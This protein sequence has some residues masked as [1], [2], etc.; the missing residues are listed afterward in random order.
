MKMMDFWMR[1]DTL[2]AG[3]E[4]CIDR[5][6]GSCHPGFPN[7]VY[8]LDYGYL[9][10]TAGG[11]GNEIDVWCGSIENCG[12]VAVICTVDTTK[13]DSEVKLIVGCSESEIKTIDRFHNKGNMSGII[14]R[15][16]L[17]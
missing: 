13:N 2:L 8:P 3:H 12:L 11:D 15:R 17:K 10:S 4:I 9:K 7:L 14:I 5:P 16:P 1:L 6:K